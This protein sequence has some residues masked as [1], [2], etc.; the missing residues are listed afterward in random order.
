VNI[1]RSRHP[2]LEGSQGNYDLRGHG[3]DSQLRAWFPFLHL[4][5]HEP[6]EAIVIGPSGGA[7]T[8][9]AWRVHQEVPGG[10]QEGDD[11]FV[12]TLFFYL[13]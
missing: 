12:G 7:T 13:R 2:A 8:H 1:L 4:L 6:A 10:D 5:E 11:V 3:F 9:S